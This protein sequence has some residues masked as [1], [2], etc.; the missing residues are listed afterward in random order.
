MKIA[1]SD[2]VATPAL[3]SLA[4]QERSTNLTGELTGARERVEILSTLANTSP[5]DLHSDK[6]NA[7]GYTESNV[8]PVRE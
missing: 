5:T 7:E 8:L 6:S 3:L 4:I 1:Q 2:K